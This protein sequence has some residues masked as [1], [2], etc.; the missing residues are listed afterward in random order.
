MIFVTSKSPCYDIGGAVKRHVA[1]QSLQT[2]LNSP[3]IL[4]YKAMLDL[5]ENEILRLKNDM[6]VGTLTCH[7]E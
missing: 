7:M 2:P 1:K 4:D 3:P 6:K 5:C